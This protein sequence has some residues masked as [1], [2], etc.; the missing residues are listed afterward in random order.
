MPNEMMV[1]EVA[2]GVAIVVAHAGRPLPSGDELR[3]EFGIT[4]PSIIKPLSQSSHRPATEAEKQA[5]R[6]ALGASVSPASR[7]TAGR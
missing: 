1:A 3:H 5:A 7:K 2:G 4:D 6:D